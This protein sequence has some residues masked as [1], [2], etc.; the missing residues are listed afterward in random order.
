M[1]IKSRLAA[2]EK[3][4]RDKGCKSIDGPQPPA[5]A[6]YMRENGAFDHDGYRAAADRWSIEVFGKPLALVAEEIAEAE[7]F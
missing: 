4:A 7:D 3:I 6:D 2:L 5:R 1:S